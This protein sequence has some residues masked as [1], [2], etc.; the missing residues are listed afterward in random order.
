MQAP[1]SFNGSETSSNGSSGDQIKA[2]AE[3]SVEAPI[4]FRGSGFHGHFHGSSGSNGSFH[5]SSG[6]F[7][8][9]AASMEASTEAVEEMEAPM[10]AVEASRHTM[11]VVEV[12]YHRWN[13]AEANGSKSCS[14]DASME[15][16]SYTHLT[17]PTKA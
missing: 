16:V 5:G 7:Q 14:S 2:A 4:Y 13:F 8:T 6:S 1:G 9:Q 17:L 15:A 10:E 12:T 3:A 11:K